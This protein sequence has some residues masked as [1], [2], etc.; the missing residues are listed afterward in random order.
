MKPMTW[1]RVFISRL[2]LLDLTAISF[3]VSTGFVVSL[4][5]NEYPRVFQHGSA[6]Y[7]FGLIAL[8]FCILTVNGSRNP[9]NFGAGIDEYRSVATSA[10]QFLGLAALLSLA[11]KEGAGFFF[12]LFCSLVGVL[13]LLFGRYTLRRWLITR[14]ET[15]GIYSSRVFLFGDTQSLKT[16]RESLL[17]ARVYG[18]H[19]IDEFNEGEL[20]AEVRSSQS[21]IINFLHERMKSVQADTLLIA[22]GTVTSPELIRELGWQID[23]QSESLVLAESLVDVAGPRI[24]ARYVPNLSLMTVSAPTYRG[25]TRFAKRLIDIFFSLAVLIFLSPF[26]IAIGIAIKA[27][28]PGPIFFHQ[29]RVGLGG[30]LFPMHKF[31]SMVVNAEDIRASLLDDPSRNTNE[32]LFKMKDDPRVTSVG[33][34]LRRYSLDELPQFINVL[35]GEM[36]VVGPRPPLPEEVLKYEDRVR[37][38]FL[39]KPGITGLWQVSGRSDLDWRETVRFDLY[40]VENWSLI[41]DIQILWRTVAVVFRGEGAY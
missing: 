19:V 29:Q 9:K 25:A 26:F 21:S 24:E 38:R 14:R 3:A 4:V 2:A 17:R 15:D 36:S 28:S 10:A 30:K 5:L 22:G 12:L 41:Q 20:S 6:L 13:V 35:A 23:Q 18:Y 37:R 32:I 39:V 7:L 1:R 40:Y 34:F 16:V 8:W 33:R 27:T 11:V 31:R